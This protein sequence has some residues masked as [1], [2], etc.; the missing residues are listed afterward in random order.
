MNKRVVCAGEVMVE[1]APAATL[2]GVYERS[3]AGDTFNTAVHLARQAPSLDVAYFTRLGED[4]LSSAI[5]RKLAEEGVATDLVQRVAGRQP[6]LYLIDNA[7]DGERSFRYWR[8]ESPARELFSEPVMLGYPDVFYF[9]GITVAVTRGDCDGFIALL[10]D[11]AEHDCQ[12]VFDPNFRPALWRDTQEAQQHYR[13]VIAY[14]DVVLPTLD[15]DRALWGLDSVADLC[16]FY[17]DFEIGELVIK[18]DDLVADVFSREGHQRRRAEPVEAVDTTGAGDSFNAGY[19]AA[20][21]TGSGVEQ[22]LLSAQALAAGVVQV[23]GAIP[24]LDNGGHIG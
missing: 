5:V 24:S 16:N 6:G 14:C 1:M 12:L 21:L 11:L 18:G 23:R 13:R 8:G 2:A 15:D 4:S 9:S 20:R 3:F 10:A 19:L 17:R 7:P 22:A